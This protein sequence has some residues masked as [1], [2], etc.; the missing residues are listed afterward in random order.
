MREQILIVEDDLAM[1]IGIRDILEMNGYQ[2]QLAENGVE[3]LKLLE[4]YRPDLI[5]SDIMMPE[6]DGY[7]F[8]ENVRRQPAWAT[9]PFIFLTAKGQRL[10]IRIGKQLG[11][12]DYLVKSTELEDLLIAVRSKL[13]RALMVRQQ[14]RKE[15]DELKQNVLNMLSH[16]FRTPLTYITGYVDL[17]EEGDWTPEDLQKFLSRIKGG[18]TRLNR[19][20]EDFLLLVRFETDDARQAYLLDKSPF[21]NWPSLIARVFKYHHE[22]AAHR[23]VELACEVEPKL[24]L[25]EAHEAYLE[26]ALSRLIEN[27]IKFSK[28]G[29]GTVNVHVYAEDRMVCC[30]V[31]D[32]GIGIPSAELPRMFDRFHQIN[33][34]RIEQQGAGIGLAIVKGIMDLHHGEVTCASLEGAGSEFILHLPAL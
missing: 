18:S 9:V 3:G 32:D 17:I 27:G 26:S 6:M 28:Q 15:M 12:D 19:L 20:V 25:V 31:K 5:I 21:N 14:S 23:L 16:E 10:D 22:Q 30:A 33:R 34:Q 24:P 13:D 1:S 2:V 11:A 7:E 4:T 29:G 8:L